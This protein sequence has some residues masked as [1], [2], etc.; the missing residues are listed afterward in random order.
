[1]MCEKCWAD[2][3]MRTFKNPCKSQSDHYFDLIEERKD[4]PCTPKQQAGQFWDEENQIDS[5][6]TTAHGRKEEGDDHTLQN[7]L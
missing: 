3:F 2:A 7:N 1:M 6:L 4:N 5:R